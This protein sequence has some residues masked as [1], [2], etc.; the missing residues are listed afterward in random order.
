[1]LNDV[2]DI[3]NDSTLFTQ[4]F[5][6]GSATKPMSIDSIV[7]FAGRVNNIWWLIHLCYFDILLFISLYYCEYFILYNIFDSVYHKKYSFNINRSLNNFLLYF[8]NLGIPGGEKL[9]KQLFINLLIFILK[10][11]E[12]DH[13]KWT[14]QFSG[15]KQVL[16][17]AQN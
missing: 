12:L 9:T 11:L 13:K 10:M 2:Y 3:V 17:N 5:S 7:F 14:R 4:L 1:M 15:N 6:E 8:H 16:Q